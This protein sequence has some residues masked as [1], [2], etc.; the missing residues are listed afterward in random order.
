MRNENNPYPTY[1][2]KDLLFMPIGCLITFSPY[3]FIGGMVVMALIGVTLYYNV[4]I[5]LLGIG[6]PDYNNWQTDA[7][8]QKIT[9]GEKTWTIQYENSNTSQYKGLVRHISPIRLAE[10]PYL[11]QDILVTTG[12]YSDETKV[13][14]YVSDHHFSW[15][16]RAQAHPEGSIHLLHA[17]PKNEQLY[18]QLLNI[19]SGDQVIISG[20]E[21][22]RINAQG[23]NGTPVW[24]WQDSGCNSLLITSVKILK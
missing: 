2:L 17:V 15:Y 22:G 13:F 24:W 5:D 8:F 16:S 3:L 1:T 4:N 19:R 23:A 21:I 9:M 7:S 11:T 18:R 20:I 10:F 12:D 6:A 14:T